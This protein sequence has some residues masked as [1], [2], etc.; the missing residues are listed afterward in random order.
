MR[1]F[2]GGEYKCGDAG[3]VF[4]IHKE[5]VW[6]W[7]K[8]LFNESSSSPLSKEGVSRIKNCNKILDYNRFVCVVFSGHFEDAIE[9]DIVSKNGEAIT[10]K[11]RIKIPEKP[12]RE[13]GNPDQI[14]V[15]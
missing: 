11:P 2:P 9:R 10:E 13:I 12:Y 1:G 6:C 5:K 4:Q 7:S 3:Y 8:D 14:V 15:Q